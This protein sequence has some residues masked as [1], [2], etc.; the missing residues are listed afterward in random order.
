MLFQIT[1][2]ETIICCDLE[3]NPVTLTIINSQKKKKACP[4][5]GFEP[6]TPFLGVVDATD[7]ANGLGNG[8]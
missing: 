7:C 5:W 6:L 4:S 8:C 3:M 1:I 2:V